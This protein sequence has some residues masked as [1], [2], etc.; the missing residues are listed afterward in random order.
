MS[1]VTFDTS[2]KADKQKTILFGETVTN[3]CSSS[4]IQVSPDGWERKINVII[5]FGMHLEGSFV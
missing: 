1:E 5:G 2:Y 3:L 4:I